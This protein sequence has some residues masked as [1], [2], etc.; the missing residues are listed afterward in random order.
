[1]KNILNNLPKI[2]KYLLIAN[3]IMFLLT[4]LFQYI[5]IDLYQYL[6]AFP[7][8]SQHFEP[9]Q[10]ITYQFMHGSFL[11]ILFNMVGLYFICPI[12]E[13][14]M[15]KYKFLLFYLISGVVSAGVFLI[16]S[17][18]P[19]VGASGALYGCIAGLAIYEPEARFSI[20]FL[21][22][23]SFKAKHFIPVLFLY[24]FVMAILPLN[25]GVGHWAH[26]FG[27][28]AGA[29]LFL[30]VRKTTFRSISSSRW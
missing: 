23:W 21:P 10:L 30:Y 20:I 24:E 26:I 27:G 4:Y 17:D 19:L 28:I 8:S 1:M 11:H 29:L 14:Y 6:A 15:G 7:Y 12:L 9:L 13:K 18:A 5:G 25:D 22:F 3:I 16:F 2:T